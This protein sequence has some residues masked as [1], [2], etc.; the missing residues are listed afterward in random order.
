V[1]DDRFRL[2]DAFADHCRD[3]SARLLTASGGD[4]AH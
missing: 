4:A 2:S 1:R 3:L